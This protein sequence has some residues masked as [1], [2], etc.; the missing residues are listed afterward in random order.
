[1]TFVI[2]AASEADLPHLYEM[3]KLTGGGFTNLP[4]DRRALKAKLERSSTAFA[5]TEGALD[6]EAFV[7]ILE[8]TE[9]GEVRGTC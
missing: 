3:A 5:R 1:M 4:A 6:D 7:L 8:N 9:T 2:R